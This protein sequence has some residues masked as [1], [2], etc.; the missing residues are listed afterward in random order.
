MP[1]E[2][3]QA[4]VLRHANYRENDRMLT[5]LSPE[6][7]RIDVLSRGCRKPRSALLPSS[8]VFVHGEF[9]LFSQNGKLTLT[10]CAIT[11]SFFPLRLDNDLLT[12]GMYLLELAQAA[13]VP[14]Q[15][16]RELYELTLRALY[17]LCYDSSFAPLS[18]VTAYLLLFASLMGYRPRLNHCAVCR[19][20]L[21][22]SRGALLFREAGGLCCAGCAPKSADPI[23]AGAVDWMRRTLATGLS[24]EALQ[25][26]ASGLFEPMRRYVESRL[27]Y[28]IRSSR[29]LP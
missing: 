15:P 18:L 16:A 3:L 8:E 26:G 6:R 19:R 22:T 5:L 25:N 14:E 9:V 20:A 24:P 13:A 1:S 29:F 12:C 28:T 2:T 7:G 17:L 27:D 23:S 10:S 21:D 11:D 4:L